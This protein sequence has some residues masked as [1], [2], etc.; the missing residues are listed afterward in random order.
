ML[1]PH[2]TASGD[3]DGSPETTELVLS[4]IEQSGTWQQADLTMKMVLTDGHE[5][6]VSTN[7]DTARLCKLIGS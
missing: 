2:A 4:Q 6:N 3:C 7:D 5:I 1:A